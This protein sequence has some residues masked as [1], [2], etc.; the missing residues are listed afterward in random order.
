M[1]AYLEIHDGSERRLPLT[2]GSEITVG[3]SP[4]CV[5][6]IADPSVSRRH[7]R[8]RRV[9]DGFVLEDLG[10][11]NGTSVNGKPVEAPV[12]LKNEDELTLG[13]VSITFCDPPPPPRTEAATMAFRVSEPATLHA[14]EP[15]TILAPPS[16]PAGSKTTTRAA[17]P[18]PGS[19]IAPQPQPSPP[20]PSIT[21]ADLPEPPHGVTRTRPM[22]REGPAEPSLLELAAIGV[23]SFF[24]VAAIGWVLLRFVL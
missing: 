2:D 7:A 15:E 9:E 23:G 19:S 20:P 21:T 10:S 17:V 18:P 22:L 12:R 3:R 8:V 6:V 4:D 5:I 1:A 24:A 14:S 13:A 11:A 16:E